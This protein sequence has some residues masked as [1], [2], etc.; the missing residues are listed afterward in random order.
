MTS[1]PCLTP[2]CAVLAALRTVGV[3]GG[4]VSLS[5]RA[6]VLGRG[7]RSLLG[8]RAIFPLAGVLRSTH[9]ILLR[10]PTIKM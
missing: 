5:R 7:T 10:P 2:G 9:S 8:Y 1:P 4:A 3:P 6:S